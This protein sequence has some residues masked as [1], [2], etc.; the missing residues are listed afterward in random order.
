LKVVKNFDE[1]YVRK[2]RQDESLVT[3]AEKITSE[4]LKI[5]WN[6][7]ADK[8]FNKVRAFSPSPGA[9]SHVVIGGDVKRVKI[10]KCDAI[11][12]KEIDPPG[13]ALVDNKT[14]SIICGTGKLQIYEMQIEGKNSITAQ[15][16]VNGLR[17]SAFFQVKFF[18]LENMMLV[19]LN[20]SF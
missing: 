2:V 20:S 8:C 15:E 12:S 14:L 4:D 6:D 18:F 1:Y 16:F 10:K 13:T 17:T 7:S 3:Y 11:S 19:Y 5:N 9:W